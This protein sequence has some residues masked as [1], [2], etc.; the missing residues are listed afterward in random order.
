MIPV[1]VMEFFVE[2]GNLRVCFWLC[3]HIVAVARCVEDGN[4]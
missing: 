3:A 1:S 4:D 2:C